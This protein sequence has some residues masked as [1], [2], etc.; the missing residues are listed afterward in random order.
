MILYSFFSFFLLDTA[1]ER[2]TG[3]QLDIASEKMSKS[4]YNGVEPLPVI[5]QYGM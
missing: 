1:F 4:K 3:L 2:A 5:D